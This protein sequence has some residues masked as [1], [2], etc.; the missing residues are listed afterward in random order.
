[1]AGEIRLVTSFNRDGYEQYGKKFLRSAEA[2]LSPEIE[3]HVFVEGFTLEAPFHIH[4]LLAD[5]DLRAFD[6]TYGW[7]DS[8]NYRFRASKFARKVFAKTSPWLPASGWRVWLDADT[9]FIGQVTEVWSPL[10]L[11]RDIA[12]LGRKDWNHSECG[13]V[14]YNLDNP[15]VRDFLNEFRRVYTSGEIW[16]HMEWHDSYLFDRCL[17]CYPK[18]RLN[19]LSEGV[20][21]L[22]VW[23]H[24]V[25][26]EKLIHNKGNLKS[27]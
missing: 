21:G 2:F 27:K 6:K 17:E 7:I 3:L 23:P 25:L 18:L 26:A 4:D 15:N 11:D 19:N 14:G 24:T 12:Y 22:H 8:P 1:M 10:I 16:G 9:E 13:F 20:P 5:E